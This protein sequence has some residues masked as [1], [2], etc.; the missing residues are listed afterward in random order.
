MCQCLCVNSIS[1]KFMYRE[2]QSACVCVFVCVHRAR[3]LYIRKKYQ[4]NHWPLSHSL[5]FNSNVST[6]IENN[7]L[8]CLCVLFEFMCGS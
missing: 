6:R 4:N 8:F 3:C 2:A 5:E 1:L 7:F